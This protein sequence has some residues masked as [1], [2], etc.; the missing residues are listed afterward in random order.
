MRQ[1][2]RRSGWGILMLVCLVTSQDLPPAPPPTRVVA[3]LETQSPLSSAALPTTDGAIALSNLQAQI[4]AEERLA[5]YGPLTV[6]QR[7]AIAEL[8]LMRG[9]FLGRIVDY[10]YAEALVEQLVS[11]VPSDG[12]AFLARVQVR[13]TLHRFAAALADLAEAERLGVNSD[14]CAAVRATILQASGRYDEALA[15]RQHLTQARPDIRS[16]GAEAAL[17]AERGEI[18]EA[19]RLFVKAQQQY[20]DVSPFPVVW[21]Y[22]QQGLMWM[23]EGELERARLAFEAACARLPGYAAAQGH[24]AM[25]EAALARRERAMAVFHRWMQEEDLAQA[26]EESHMT[27]TSKEAAVGRYERAIVLLRQQAN[28][29]DDPEYASQLARLLKEVGQLD[30]AQHWRDIAAARYDE[31]MVRHPEAFADHAAEFWLTVGGDV[32]KGRLLAAQ[33]FEIRKT[34]RAYELVLQAAVATHETATVCRVAE[35]LRTVEQQGPRLRVL[36]V[37]ALT[38]CRRLSPSSAEH[39]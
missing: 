38:I 21:L 25:V 35:H 9:Q 11:D 7:A 8:L 33:N 15:I 28:S 16:L 37:R 20:R 6:S 1:Y 19:E 10:E 29:S 23:W 14:R 5:S 32:H 4:A 24:L 22:F 17:R 34:P 2:L 31:L 3:A 12:R 36:A 18:D 27:H 30:E 13:A 39:E 26:R